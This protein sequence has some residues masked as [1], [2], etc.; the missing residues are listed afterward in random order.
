MRNFSKLPLFLLLGWINIFFGSLGWG[1][2]ISLGRIELKGQAVVKYGKG[3]VFK[4]PHDAEAP[5]LVGSSIE[6]GNVGQALLD[7]PGTGLLILPEDSEGELKVD[8]FV[9]KDGKIITRLDPDQ[10]VVIEAGDCRFVVVA[11]SN[12]VGIAAIEIKNNKVDA[13]CESGHI[14]GYCPRRGAFVIW[15]KEANVPFSSMIINF[16][17]IAGGFSAFKSGRDEE[18]HISPF[19]P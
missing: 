10:H 19:T 8:S 17:A 4:A 1:V 18:R 3:L 12:R 6:T 11:P 7:W 14:K 16:G 2:P 5:M 9:L 15:G 13:S